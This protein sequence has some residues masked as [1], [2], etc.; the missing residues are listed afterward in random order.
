MHLVLAGFLMACQVRA[1][2]QQPNPAP[3]AQPT[4]QEA[5][6]HAAMAA[7][8]LVAVRG[9]A[10][11]PLSDQAVLHLSPNFVFIPS[12]EAR[13]ILQAMGNRTGD[14]MLGVIFPTSDAAA[15]SFIAVQYIKSGYIRDDDAKDWKADELLTNL[16]DGTEEVNKERKA[17]GIPEMEVVGWVER[18]QYDSTAHQLKWSISTKDKGAADVSG[19]GI[20]YNTYALGREGFISMNLVTSLQSVEAQKPL[21]SELLAGLKFNDGKTYGDFNSSTDKVAEY[22]LA[23]LVAGVAAKKLGLLA[24]AGVFFAKFAKA[25]A[26]GAVALAGGALKF[27]RKKPKPTAVTT[28][29][30]AAGFDAPAKTP[31]DARDG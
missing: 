29:P 14:N 3:A 28:A 12:K 19:K 15:N 31:S 25:I 11:I 4:T 13:M 2:A 24:L 27:W 17:R 30:A 26:I 21:V 23:A 20:N 16:K 9:P 10:E 18:P 5:Q 8:K 6:M 1:F 22:G 7:A